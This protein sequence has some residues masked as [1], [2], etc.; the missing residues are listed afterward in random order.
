GRPFIGQL[1]WDAPIADIQAT[2]AAAKPAGGVAVVGY[3]WGGSLAFLS[4]VKVDGLAC[5][6]GYY[7]GQIATQLDALP[8]VPLMLH[9]GEQDASIPQADVEKIRGAVP[10]ATVFTYPGAGHGFSCD[11]RRSHEPSSAAL[12]RER[13]LAF[14]REHVG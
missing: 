9:F 2:V 5:A 7:G 11:A 1:G 3:C 10:G 4:A 14:I 8:R 12:A 13:T 6:V